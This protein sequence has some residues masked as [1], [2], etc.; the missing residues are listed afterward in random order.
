MLI[1]QHSRIVTIRLKKWM[2]TSQTFETK[3]KKEELDGR[4]KINFLRLQ[5]QKDA[6][7]SKEDFGFDSQ[8]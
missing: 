8:G 2:M 1:T 3:W 6:E 5:G 4:T 7:D